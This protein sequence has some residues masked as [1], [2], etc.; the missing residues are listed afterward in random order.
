MFKVISIYQRKI[1]RIYTHLRS[2]SKRCFVGD[3]TT[4]SVSSED[5][6]FL[7]Y[8]YQSYKCTLNSV[9]SLLRLNISTDS[10]FRLSVR[11][12]FICNFCFP[13]TSL[14]YSVMFNRHHSLFNFY[15]YLFCR[16][17]TFF[18]RRPTH[19][20]L[21]YTRESQSQLNDSCLRSPRAKGLQS[22]TYNV[23]GFVVYECVFP[24]MDLESVPPNGQMSLCQI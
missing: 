22:Y 9:W 10:L 1:Q 24:V 16:T 8:S 11:V 13:L 18:F 2:T 21:A 17:H 3:T 20:S 12:F 5:D 19:Y 15:F 23:E 14:F 7:P 6:Y 4:F